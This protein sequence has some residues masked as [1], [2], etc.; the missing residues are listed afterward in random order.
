[1]TLSRE[2][3]ISDFEKTELI[4]VTTVSVWPVKFKNVNKGPFTVDLIT[5]DNM[6][7]CWVPGAG[8]FVVS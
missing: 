7:Y 1:M 2:T 5:M 6:V 8:F 4:N 3:I